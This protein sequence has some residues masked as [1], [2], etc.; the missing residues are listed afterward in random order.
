M[1]LSKCRG[2]RICVAVSGGIDSVSLLHDLQNHREAYGYILSAVHCQ[3]G[4]RGEDSL[5]DMR[6]VQDLCNR[7]GVPLTIFEEDCIA[8]AK[9]E[10]CSLE[11]SA[12][13]FRYE[14]FTKL[15]DG[16]KADY[17]ATAH[18]K[19]DE[20]ETVLFRLARGTSLTGAR[21]MT[22]ESAY[23]LRPFLFWT[24]ADIERY[25]KEN[26]LSHRE[27]CTNAQTD[28]TRNKLRLQVLPALEDAVPGAVEN[29][30]RFAQLAGEDDEYLYRQ[31]KSLL[32]Q[33][34]VGYMVAFSVEKPLFK[35]ACLT[36]LKALGVERD[37]T[38]VHL[39]LLFELQD[40]QRGAVLS[41]PK[42]VQAQKMQKGVYLY[43]TKALPKLA[44]APKYFTANGF[45]GGRYEVKIVAREEDAQG[46]CMPVLR[47]DMDKIPPNAVFRFRKDG[48][49]MK[50]FGGKTKTLKKLFNERK[51]DV[52][53]REALPVIADGNTGEIYVV[54]GVEIAD[55][56]KC[57]VTTK[58]VGYI[59]VIEK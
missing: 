58:R 35:R 34:S 33:H 48:D 17:I 12:R 32:S 16:D 28:A 40:K 51:T 29:L 26:G 23:I 59:V 41:M 24:R 37:Y 1:D 30:A 9:Q 14:C 8:R 57:D 18:H 3:H 2:K 6:F 10:K 4:I 39:E 56:V 55:I 15:I 20:A 36:A 45:D 13:H 54:C 53:Q 7:Y 47:V 46:A 43:V 21:G 31:S 50:V 49:K 22:E 25:A 27:D 5:E 42:G 19:N 44:K 52:R 38:R 11:T